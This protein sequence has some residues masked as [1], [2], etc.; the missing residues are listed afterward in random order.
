MLQMLVKPSGVGL[1]LLKACAKIERP[2][3]E[4]IALQ[5]GD[6]FAGVDPI[7]YAVTNSS[8]AGPARIP[9]IIHQTW[10]DDHVPVEWQA[11]QESCRQMHPDFEYKLWTDAQSREFIAAKFPE[12]LKTWDKYPFNIQRADIIRSDPPYD[13]TSISDRVQSVAPD[14]FWMALVET[15]SFCT[16]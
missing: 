9:K 6:V 15:K 14:S 12:L 4:V 10:K 3:H 2:V 16:T 13:S 11:A 8:A 1:S 7:S 5:L